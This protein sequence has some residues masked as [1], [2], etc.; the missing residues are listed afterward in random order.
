MGRKKLYNTP[1]KL[2]KAARHY[3]DSISYYEESER[4]NALGQHLRYRVWM[5]SPSISGLC[6]HL[7]FDRRTW[8]N[9][10]DAKINPELAPVC[11][12]A[13]FV[14]EQYLYEKSLTENNRGAIFNLQNNFGYSEKREVE[15][16][17][18]TR[19]IAAKNGMTMDEKLKLIRE[20]AEE[21]ADAEPGD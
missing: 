18:Q 12:W 14:I 21:M 11:A 9:Y 17:R 8:A 6:L 13:K 15:M 2:E 5:E 1:A 10:S 3:F 16:G 7:G 19:A 20:A 4:L